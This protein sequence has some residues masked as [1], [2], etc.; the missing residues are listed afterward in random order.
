VSDEQHTGFSGTRYGMT[1]R[2]KAAVRFIM[3]KR[4]G[5]WH[6]GDCVGGDEETHHIARMFGLS[7]EVHPPIERKLRAFCRGNVVHPPKKYRTRNQDIVNASSL[8]IAAPSQETEVLT[9]GTWA[10]IR[11][12]RKI[13]KP[14]AI[15]LPDGSVTWE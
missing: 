12:A 14:R 3:F 2:Q 8:L 15:V 1:T 5:W 7:I 13:G 9:S 10:T 11:Y 4:T 6:H